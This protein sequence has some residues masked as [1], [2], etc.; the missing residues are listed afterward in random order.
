ME[1]IIHTILKHDTKD[2]MMNKIHTA[3]YECHW[4]LAMSAEIL[5]VTV[6][7]LQKYITHY[8]MDFPMVPAWCFK[9]PD[10]DTPDDGELPDD[11][12]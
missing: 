10:E 4:A 2:Q 12:V 1:N 5:G 9:K 8:Q 11:L 7:R 3:M 6:N